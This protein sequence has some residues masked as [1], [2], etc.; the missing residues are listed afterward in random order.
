MTLQ[1]P[2]QYATIQAA[3][4]ESAIGDTVL[5]APG[6]Y[7]E[8]EIRNPDGGV[9]ERACVFMT[10]GVVLRSS[11]GPGTTTI[12][13]LGAGDV[14]ARVVRAEHLSSETTQVEGFTLT[15]APL[16][17][18][19]AYVVG[20]GR[21]TFRECVFRDMDAGGGSGGGL[22]ANGD[23]DVIDC[24]FVNCLGTTGGGVYHANGHINIVGTT[25]RECEKGAYL[26]G[27]N[28]GGPESAVIEDCVFLNNFA[29]GGGGMQIAAYGGGAIVRRCWF[30]GNTGSVDAGGLG[31]GGSGSKVVEDCVFVNNGATGSGAEGG[32]ISILGPATIRSTT[33]VNNYNN[34]SLSGGSTLEVVNG[35][36]LENVILVGSTGGTAITG[37]VTT[38]CCV[39][40][41]NPEGLGIELGDTDREIDPQFCDPENDD[42]TVSET[43][44]C[45]EPGS[46]GCGQIGAFGI[47]CGTTAIDAESWGKI[48]AQFREGERP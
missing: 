23:V 35:A 2:G 41:D 44:P 15:G 25:F 29:I 6:T 48:K 22:V 13:L 9:P 7:T 47:G 18:G 4:D 39:F 24:E 26:S 1:V 14:P 30:E 31:W 12:D 27:N 46:L 17:Y 36:L 43:S 11:G 19:G 21:V 5:V 40:W 33:F 10:D 28:V 34:G 37:S 42:F 38:S 32:A 45:V 8:S 16:G 3:M 20:P